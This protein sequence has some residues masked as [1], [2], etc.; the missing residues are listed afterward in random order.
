MMTVMDEKVIFFLKS[1]FEINIISVQKIHL[2]TTYVKPAQNS[3][4]WVVE[5]LPIYFKI[6]LNS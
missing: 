3:V 6:S 5:F 4:N 1:S 2:T